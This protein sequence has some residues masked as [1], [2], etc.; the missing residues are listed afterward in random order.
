[1]Y[2][3]YDNSAQIVA[4]LYFKT[5][6]VIKPW[7]DGKGPPFVDIKSSQFSIICK[8]LI[9]EKKM[10]LEIHSNEDGVWTKTKHASPGNISQVLSLW[11]FRSL[12]LRVD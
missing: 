2:V 6:K 5:S 1:M 10:E 7:K 11:R 12:F 9:M 8:S 3:A 4:D